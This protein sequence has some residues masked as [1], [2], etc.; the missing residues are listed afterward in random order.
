[1]RGLLIA[2]IAGAYMA[3]PA[4]AS[5]QTLPSEP[6][7]VLDGRLVLTGE[8]ALTVGSPDHESYFNYTDYERNALRTVRLSLAALWQP[9]ERL[10]FVGELRSEDVESAGAYAAYVRFRPWHPARR[11]HPNP[12]ACSTDDSCSAA[13]RP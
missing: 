12:C 6:V 10:A 1:M 2:F 9:A 7:R 13:T 8:A 11:C 4:A 5:A 3:A